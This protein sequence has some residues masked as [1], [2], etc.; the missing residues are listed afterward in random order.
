MS[1]SFTTAHYRLE[2]KILIVCFLLIPLTLLILFTLYPV[3]AM[4]YYSFTDWNGYGVPDGFVGLKNYVEIFT[5]PKYWVVFENSLYYLVAGLLQQVLGLALAALLSQKVR[6]SSFFKGIVFFPYLI[7]AV[8]VSFIFLMFY[9]KDGILDSFLEFLG[10]ANL[11]QMWIADQHIVKFSLAFTALWRSFGYSFIIYTGA[12]QSISS[13]IY[14]AAEIDGANALQRMLRITIPN[15]KMVIGLML[16]MT[17]I[18]SLS[19]FDIPYIMTKAQNGTNTFISTVIDVAFTYNQFGLA[20]AL[21]VVLLIMI[22]LIT[23]LRSAL[24]KEET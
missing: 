10:L 15:I 18:G 12:M 20:S 16:M 7:N 8:A 24:L 23:L 11:S 2:K 21:S 5:N 4:M 13:E 6:F 1:R 9:E 3:C 14:E 19:A 17:I 22:T